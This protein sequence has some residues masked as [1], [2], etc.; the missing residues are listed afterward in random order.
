MWRLISHR[1][2]IILLAAAAAISEISLR[3]AT[4]CTVHCTAGVCTA[5]TGAELRSLF[6]S[7]DRDGGT[8]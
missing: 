7:G 1:I 5:V 4:R 3:V 6:N 8:L 2:K